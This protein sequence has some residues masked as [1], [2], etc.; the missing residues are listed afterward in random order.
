MDLPI[1]TC[2]AFEIAFGSDSLGGSLSLDHFHGHVLG[3]VLFLAA[4][5]AITLA[6]AFLVLAAA[7]A[8]AAALTIA[9]AGAGVQQLLGPGDNA[10][11]I[12][13]GHIDSTGNSSQ[14]NNNLNNNI[15]SFHSSSSSIFGFL[16]SV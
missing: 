2:L 6:A 1:F 5:L 7:L 13:S 9:A 12:S 10:I 11:A 16:N 14:S 3:A 15:Q 8:V 4:A